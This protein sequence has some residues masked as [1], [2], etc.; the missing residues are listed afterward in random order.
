MEA[1]GIP[2]L[3]AFRALTK[4]SVKGGSSRC[5]TTVYYRQNV[6]LASLGILFIPWLARLAF[7]SFLVFTRAVSGYRILRVQNELTVVRLSSIL[8]KCWLTLGNGDGNERGKNEI[9]YHFFYY[10][11]NR[12]PCREFSNLFNLV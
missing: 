12:S 10:K 5:A 3:P 11:V 1:A 9:F 8:L 4:V 6:A 7:S 2:G